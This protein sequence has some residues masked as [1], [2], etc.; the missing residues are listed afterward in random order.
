MVWVLLSAC[1]SPPLAGE[2]TA[3]V[4][5][6]PDVAPA[7]AVPAPDAPPDVAVDVAPTTP[8]SAVHLL[9]TPP[10]GW[11]DLRV[12]LLGAQFDVRYHTADNFVGTPLPGYG[13]PGAWMRTEAAAALV[14]VHEALGERGF[15]VKIY[16]AY[17][18][19]R[20]TKAMVA[21][22]HRTDQVFLL[23]NGYIARRSHH[24]RGSTVD[25]SVFDRATG[26]ELDMG[27]EWD[28]LSEASHTRNATGVAL[29]NRLLLRD[30]MDSNG[31][32]PYHKEWWHFVFRGDDEWPHRDVPYGCHEPAEGAWVEPTDWKTPG[33]T[34]PPLD[35]SACR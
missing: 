26:A 12:A 32:E 33:W 23:D 22:A 20:G 29:E 34:P 25:L 4:P 21:W 16:D 15:G 11:T 10:D 8:E 19:F 2:G 30:L 31:F 24:N 9:N 1:A 13:A 27:T 3:P 14:R 7:A 18:P 5:P 35:L 17:R 6:P 28:T